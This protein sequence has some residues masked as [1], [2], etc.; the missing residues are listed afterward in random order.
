VGPE[1]G[2]R[3]QYSVV[4]AGARVAWS[5][6][7]LELGAGVLVNPKNPSDVTVTLGLSVRF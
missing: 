1:V 2:F 4:L 5:P 6:G 7:P 3:V